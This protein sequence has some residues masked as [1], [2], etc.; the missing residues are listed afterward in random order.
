MDLSGL[1]LDERGLVTVVAQD[2][3]TGE[4]RMVAHANEEALRRTA[5]TGLACF[6]SRSRDRPWQKGEE[7]GN[8]LRVS[9]IWLDCDADAVIYLVEPEGPSCH[10]GRP[11][12]FFRRVYPSPGADS[13][14]A[15][16]VLVSL[17]QAL[18]RRRSASAE[19]SYTRSLLDGGA[20]KIGDKLREE[21]D[22]LA[23]ALADESD[24]RVCSEAADLVY[25]LM[26]G[27][28]HRDVPLADVEAELAKRF[29]VSGH[30]EKAARKK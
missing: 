12:C 22:E 24:E 8:V 15:L 6:F 29:G 13:E 20:P 27:L 9:E 1:K 7:S 16:P 25:H 5:R 30:D 28:L 17:E 19:R 11:S 3:R 26:V 10:T 4:V 18:E 2:Q 23:R 14:R 21:A